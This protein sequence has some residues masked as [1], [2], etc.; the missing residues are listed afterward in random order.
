MKQ[1]NNL[2]IIYE[3]VVKEARP[4]KDAVEEA[5]QLVKKLNQFAFTPIKDENFAAELIAERLKPQQLSNPFFKNLSNNSS[6]GR[7]FQSQ[8]I[9]QTFGVFFIDI[10]FAKRK[11][12][13]S[14]GSLGKSTDKIKTLIN[15][16]KK[17][18]S[19]PQYSLRSSK[20]EEGNHRVAALEE[21]GYKSVP[22]FLIDA[23]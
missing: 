22:V 7:V 5:K 15:D 14:L 2:N 18:Q 3:R 17:L 8:S 6:S 9:D 12:G 23:W 4:S 19:V 10:K 1:T 13:N 16:G 20:I 21:L 11:A